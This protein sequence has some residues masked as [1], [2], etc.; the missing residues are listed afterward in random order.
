MKRPTGPEDLVS[1]AGRWVGPSFVLDAH[2]PR[3]DVP[4]PSL[5]EAWGESHRH[6]EAPTTAALRWLASNA[7]NST[8]SSSGGG[9]STMVDSNDANVLRNTFAVYGTILGLMLVSF[10]VVRV[11][12]PRAYT[13]RQWAENLKVTSFTLFIR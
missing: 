9:N 12:F 3:R 5:H 4:F 11:R 7:T 8:N 1:L 13:V 10:C 6:D 2:R